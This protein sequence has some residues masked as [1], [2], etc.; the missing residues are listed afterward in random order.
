VLTLK[1]GETLV[2]RFSNEPEF[3]GELRISWEFNILPNKQ[4]E[5]IKTVLKELAMYVTATYV[6]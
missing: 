6:K 5:Q 3:S 2:I 1:T 4:Q